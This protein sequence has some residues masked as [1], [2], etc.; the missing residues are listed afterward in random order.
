[1]N[2]FLIIFSLKNALKIGRNSLKKTILFAEISPSHSF[3]VNHKC[4]TFAPNQIGK[5]G[6]KVFSGRPAKPGGLRKK[7]LAA[8]LADLIKRGK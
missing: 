3:R 7:F 2:F 4:N 5:N 1:M 6:H 8:S